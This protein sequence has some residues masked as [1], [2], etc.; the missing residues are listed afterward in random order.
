MAFTFPEADPPATPIRNGFGG[1]F[2]INSLLT[3]T[4]SET[5]AIFSIIV[6]NYAIRDG[7]DRNFISAIVWQISS[8][9][10]LQQFRRSHKILMITKWL[11]V[12]FSYGKLW[13]ARSTVQT[14]DWEWM[15]WTVFAAYRC[16]VARKVQNLAVLKRKT[17]TMLRS[18]EEVPWAHLRLAFLRTEWRVKWVKSAWLSVIQR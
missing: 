5:D 4:K 16:H 2:F 1:V 15:I 6:M 18:L 8:C 12:A 14:T 17:F 11:P 9:V 3:G 7:R 10:T 13:L